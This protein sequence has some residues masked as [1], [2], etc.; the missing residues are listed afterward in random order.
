M[1]SIAP[2]SDGCLVAEEHGT[3]FKWL[4]NQLTLAQ[5]GPY[6][7]ILYQKEPIIKSRF[8]DRGIA[9]LIDVW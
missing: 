8:F 5:A 2:T 7:Q 4:P 6:G 9:S 1:K 3:T